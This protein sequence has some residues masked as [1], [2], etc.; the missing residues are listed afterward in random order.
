ML[1][2]LPRGGSGGRQFPQQVGPSVQM[3]GDGKRADDGD[4]DGEV[5][6]DGET[7]V[8]WQNQNVVM[9]NALAST[10]G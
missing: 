6:E 8:Q 5:D 3:H 7:A 10:E 2:H 9:E 4:D 1:L